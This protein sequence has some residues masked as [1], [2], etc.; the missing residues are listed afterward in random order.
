MN[1][2]CLVT[3]IYFHF[4]YWEKSNQTK[5]SVPKT[6]Q[7]VVAQ[8]ITPIEFNELAN[9]LSH[10]SEGNWHWDH[11]QQVLSAF[12]LL[13]T[14]F[15]CMDGRPSG[16]PRGHGLSRQGYL[17]TWQSSRTAQTLLPLHPTLPSCPLTFLSS[18]LFSPVDVVLELDADLP[19]VGLV[20]DE[21]VLHQLLR[22][23]SLAVVLH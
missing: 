2:H 14:R 6:T 22:G 11:G 10:L 4:S 7:S 19:L 15:T 23:W 8:R 9:K 3:G 18:L 16:P 1:T 21:G 13:P 5:Q 17:S 12:L 20:S